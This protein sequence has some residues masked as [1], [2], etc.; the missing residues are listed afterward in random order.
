VSP[1]LG[2][3]VG[4]IVDYAGAFPPASLACREA[5]RKYE[6]YR[7]SAH[8]WML[9]RFV[10]TAGDLDLLLPEGTAPFAVLAQQDHS[11]AE[12]IESKTFVETAKPFYWETDDLEAVAR[13]GVY[14]KFRT[15]GLTP[16][17]I[18]A[19]ETVA[20]FIERAARLRIA[21]K[22]TAGMHEPIR[23]TRAL[24][25]E[26]DSPRAPMHG[27]VNVFLA[28]CF[29]WRGMTG[30]RDVLAET[31]A[32]AFRFDEQAHWRDHS[33]HA[34]EIGEVRRNFAHAFGSCSFM[35]PVESLKALD[36]I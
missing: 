23:S 2:A 3:L 36:W 35:E 13:Y 30:V 9:G 4:N 28:A 24:T 11:R 25:Y 14:A 6:E 34:D 17:A 12:C 8:A 29:A 32:A 27:F 33:V 10:V 7:R 19:I 15:G 5:F 16:D 20:E 26:E 22:L 18:P 31:D 1:A 21:F